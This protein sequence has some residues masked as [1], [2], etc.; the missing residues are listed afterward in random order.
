MDAS[1]AWRRRSCATVEEAELERARIVLELGNRGRIAAPAR[2]MTVAE[3]WPT[4]RGDIGG[5]LAEA[6]LLDYDATWRRRVQARFGDIRLEDI[7]PREISL[8]KAELQAGGVGPEATRRA[9][10][11]LQ[12][13]F[14]LAVEW[15]ETDTNPVALVR[16]PRQG[17]TRAVA[18]LDP[19]S[20]ERIRAQLCVIADPFSATLVSVLAYSGM[21]PSEALALERRHIRADTILVEQAV[22]LG[23]LKV[24]KTGRAYRTVDLLPALRDDLE[25]WLTAGVGSEADARLFPRGDG[26]WLRLDDW[27]NW[28]NRHFHPATR[29]VGL[30]KPRA[31][32]LRHSFA[33]LLIREGQTSIVEIAEQLGH[34]PT[35]TL[36]TYAHVFSEY[37]RQPRVPAND[38]IAQAREQV[39]TIS[40]HEAKQ[41]SLF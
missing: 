5:R 10:L 3:F 18:P 11:L 33:S 40:E 20:I 23:K 7:T 21:R 13:M 24:Q 1:G 12:A 22:S 28:R 38:L 26:Q 6:T 36:K 37:R 35:E 29:A 34:S 9:M 30:G 27:N 2:E 4:Y 41:A 19:L 39:L 17:R 14:T 25:T 15:G 16:K 8:W 32:D 31:Y